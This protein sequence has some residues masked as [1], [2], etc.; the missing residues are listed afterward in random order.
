MD[1]SF[2]NQNV[3]NIKKNSKA[4]YHSLRNKLDNTIQNSGINLSWV[5]HTVKEER[6]R[7]NNLVNI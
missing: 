3:N 7:N 2:W 6:E 4:T 5:G 1:L